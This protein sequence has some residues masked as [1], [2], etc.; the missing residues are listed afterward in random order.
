M[1]IPAPHSHIHYMAQ[2]ACPDAYLSQDDQLHWLALR[3]TP[4]LGTRKAGQLVGVFRT[5]QSIFRASPSELESAGLS[6]SV[7]QSIA[8]GCAFDDA[9]T[10]HQKND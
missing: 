1:R 10:Q 2:A 4:G 7:A 5:P 3:M 9:A 8:R 6:A